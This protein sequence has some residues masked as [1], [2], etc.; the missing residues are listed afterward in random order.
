[1]VFLDTVQPRGWMALG[2]LINQ[3]MMFGT[4]QQQ[5]LRAISILASKCFCA[6]GTISAVTNNVSHFSEN[7]KRI[8]WVF[9]RDNEE[10]RTTR[11]RTHSPGSC[12]HNFCCFFA[13]TLGCHALLCS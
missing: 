11:I 5:V 13:D 2:L 8:G 12:P 3:C 10:F 9:R 7:C 4:E 6:S 1:M